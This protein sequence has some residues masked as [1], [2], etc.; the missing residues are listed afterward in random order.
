MKISGGFWENFGRIFGSWL[1]PSD[2]NFQFF[3]MFQD[4]PIS[5]QDASQD[6]SNT[7]PRRPADAT[8]THPKGG[9]YGD[10]GQTSPPL[11]AAALGLEDFGMIFR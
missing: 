1:M 6:A 2:Q 4:D 7:P 10:V 9:L 8:E 5:S 11:V 3:C